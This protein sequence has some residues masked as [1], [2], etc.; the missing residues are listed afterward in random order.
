M[1]YAR[2]TRIGNV[3]ILLRSGI[4]AG[5]LYRA[6]SLRG[7]AVPGRFDLGVPMGLD[8]EVDLEASGQSEHGSDEQAPV[9]SQRDEPG[10]RLLTSGDG[11]SPSP[12]PTQLAGM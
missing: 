4:G 10:Q 2:G 5:V 3:G 8:V 6:V 9:C 12:Q 7:R 11:H 1:L